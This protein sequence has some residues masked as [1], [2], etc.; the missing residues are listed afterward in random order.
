M[1]ITIITEKPDVAKHIANAL[2]ANIKAEGFFHGNG[3]TVTY[4][5]GH[6]F[7]LEDPEF[8]NPLYKSWSLDNL[9]ITIENYKLRLIPSAA[10]QF[11]IIKNLLDK[12]D[13]LI[14]AGDIDREGELIQNWIYKQAGYKGKIERMWFSSNT[15]E[16]LKKAFK[17]RFPADKKVNLF[18]AGEERSFAD[19]NVGIN[20]TRALT[21]SSASNTPLSIG[22]VQTPTLAMVC[23]RFL[24]NKNFKSTPYYVPFIKLSKDNIEFRANLITDK[25]ILDPQQANTLLS[26]VSNTAVCTLAEKKEVKEKQP[27]LFDLVS[28]QKECNIK[29]G[30]SAQKTLDVMQSLYEKHKVLTYPRTDS[31]YISYDIFSTV[32][33]LIKTSL[34]LLPVN[35]AAPL[36]EMGNL[37]KRSVSDQ[38]ASSHHAIIPTG[39]KPTNLTEQESLVFKSVLQRFLAA[40]LPE[41]IKSITTYQFK[42][43]NGLFK[44]SGTIINYPGWRILTLKEVEENNKEENLN[45][46]II[47][48]HE[49]IKI[50]NKG[51]ENKKTTAPALLTDEKLLDLMLKCGKD[52]D[53]S[54]EELEAIKEKGIGTSVTRSAIIEVLIKRGYILREKKY[55][56]PSDIG[57]ALYDKIKDLKITN[58]QLTGEW[59]FKLLQIERGQLD[60]N[61][62]RK[63]INAYCT[64]VVNE[65]KSIGLSLK[66][67]LKNIEKSNSIVCPLCKRGYLKEFE[68]SF[69]CSEYNRGAGC[70]FTVWKV[71]A[72]KK[73]NETQIKLLVEKGKTGLIKGF[74]GKKGKF[75]AFLILKDLKVEF[76][77]SKK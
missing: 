27:L 36:F 12:T 17:E 38:K 45:L 70:N 47:G 23:K 33:Q 26:S 31:C 54:E 76:E 2:G 9:P 5:F 28:L 67:D 34:S 55:I 37:P 10:K 11:K 6:L 77:F 1:N 72:G 50:F 22:R 8:Y 14:N 66:N 19:W 20:S 74:Q 30:F 29:F 63:E 32:P 25:P 62:F 42:S 44:A 52:V 57:L 24:D 21:V 49:E 39:E 18:I 51:I 4:A 35:G 65:L 3:L 69:S 43:G 16:A 73:I 56:L 7:S 40:F 64:E 60:R 48:I 68:K 41:C 75:D 71:V 13:L 59:E 53:L 46:P 58:P 15:D 61:V